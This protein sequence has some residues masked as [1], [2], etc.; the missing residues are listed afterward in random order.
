M[1][2]SSAEPDGNIRCPRTGFCRPARQRRAELKAAGFKDCSFV[3]ES[4]ATHGRP[5]RG[6]E[7]QTNFGRVKL[8]RLD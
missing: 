5:H 3:G 1:R 8:K 6:G 7:T 4:V 2:R